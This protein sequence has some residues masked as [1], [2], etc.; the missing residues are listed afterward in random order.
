MKEEKIKNRAR[1][2]YSQ[3]V[4]EVQKSFREEHTPHQTA[5]SFAIGSFIVLTPNFP[6]GLLALIAIAAFWKNSNEYALFAPTIILNPLVK[7]GFYS[8]S[9]YLGRKLP[10][11]FELGVA[12]TGLNLLIG[13]VVAGT[14]VAVLGYFT[15]YRL[16]RRYQS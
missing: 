8:A 7:T 9:L 13:T 2:F 14:V 15:V 6:I 16:A 11:N 1:K 4:R 5:L 12:T 3:A 10:L